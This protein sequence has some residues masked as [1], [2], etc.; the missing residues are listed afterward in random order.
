[1]TVPCP[2]TADLRSGVPTHVYRDYR[3]TGCHWLP[4]SRRGRQPGPALT[5]RQPS[6]GVTRGSPARDALPCPQPHSP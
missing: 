2:M 5:I 1:M 4:A 6:A 3:Q